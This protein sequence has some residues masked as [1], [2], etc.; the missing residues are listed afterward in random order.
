MSKNQNNPESSKLTEWFGFPFSP[1]LI[2]CYQKTPRIRWFTKCFLLLNLQFKLPILSFLQW[3]RFFTV[4]SWLFSDSVACIVLFWYFRCLDVFLFHSH[5]AL[6]LLECEAKYSVNEPDLDY[7]LFPSRS[8]K[9]VNLLFS[10]FLSFC[11]C[12][13][14]LSLFFLLASL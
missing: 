4:N 10:P 12:A 5:T 9:I 14:R 11:M 7:F 2:V 3:E 6:S 1:F 13:T 8:F